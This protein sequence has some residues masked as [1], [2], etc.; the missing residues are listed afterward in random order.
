MMSL[1]PDA[2]KI[3]TDVASMRSL[4]HDACKICTDAASMILG[5]K[6][7]SKNC[8]EKTSMKS[9]RDNAGKNC[10]DQPP[11]M[12]LWGNDKDTTNPPAVYMV[13]IKRNMQG[14]VKNSPCERNHIEIDEVEHFS[15]HSTETNKDNVQNCPIESTETTM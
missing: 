1:T 7:A 8:S 13:I 15:V 2:S 11:M 14:N 4:T 5:Q 3:C 9:L 10:S 12:L 6:N